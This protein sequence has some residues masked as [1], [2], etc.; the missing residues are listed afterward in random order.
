MN[1]F[2]YLISLLAFLLANPLS[3]GASTSQITELDYIIAIV[4]D[5]VLTRSELDDRMQMVIKQLQ[6]KD[7]R[8][9]SQE[10]LQRQVLEQLIMEKIQLQ[11]A[12]KVGVRV[13]DEA[14][15]NVLSNIA[16]TNG[17]TLQEF[18]TVLEKDGYRYEDFR[19]N[20]RNEMIIKQL[21]ERRVE[22]R[23]NVSPQEVDTYLA[24]QKN[25]KGSDIEYNLGH[26]LISLPEA[27]N[28]EQIQQAQ[29]KA[30]QVL[31][32]LREG[33]DFEQTAIAVS[34][35]QLALKG[36]QIGWRKTAQM[37]TL[38]ADIVPEMKVGEY[39][40]LIRSASGF[41]IVKLQD[42]RSDVQR[43][44]IEQT[45]ARHILIRP[46]ELRSNA[47]VEQR[48]KQLRARIINGEDFAIL[49]RSHSDDKAS[50]ADGGSL[51]WVSPGLM[52]QRFEQQM[53]QLKPGEISQPFQTRYGWHI[54]QV[55]SRRKY[56]NTEEYQRLQARNNISQRKTEEAVE[57]WL[58]RLR[59][60]AYVEYRINH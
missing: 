2:L 35:G 15:N 18:R 53:N 33:A 4:N 45:L 47:E 24:S 25:R 26:I 38:F 57:N 3:A 6:Q 34:S 52:V 32:Q 30:Q 50:A 13:N 27:A 17:L 11:R 21:R 40:D 22:N 41:H 9:P 60:E 19:E 43:H 31:K 5:D 59:S 20:I 49:A 10:V 29:Q 48:L 36:G 54:V 1:K 37:P 39:S 12:Q 56:D 58:R 8:L 44:I 23:V 51:G 42:K 7:T 16:R 14:L 46:N 28:A 55:M